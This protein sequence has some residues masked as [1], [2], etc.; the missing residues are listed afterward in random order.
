MVQIIEA[1][2]PKK[3]T[4]GQRLNVG[5]GRGLEV[6]Q[7]MMQTYQQ[8]QAAQKLG[9][10][11]QV[12]RGL[13]P[14]TRSQILGEALQQNIKVKRAGQTAGMDMSS[15]VA[16]EGMQAPQ[17]RPAGRGQE[18]LEEMG[19]RRQFEAPEF[20]AGKGRGAQGPSNMPQEVTGGVKKPIVG[21]RDKLL[22]DAKTIQLNTSMI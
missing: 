12:M 1:G 20:T 5:V 6:G 18:F 15:P 21:G 7:Q 14:Q 19:Q 3:P 22:A 4:F 10:D 13:D 8:E 11:P 16:K 9:L 17:E 2:T